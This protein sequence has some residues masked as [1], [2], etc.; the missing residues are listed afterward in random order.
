MNAQN[1]STPEIE[2]AVQAERKRCFDV[3]MDLPYWGGDG[4]FP[5]SHWN[6]QSKS[7]AFEASRL[8]RDPELDAAWRA[9][10][11]RLMVKGQQS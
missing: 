10:K 8:I 7:F 9:G 5:L 3:V 6:A 2:A 4:P 11:P 1:T